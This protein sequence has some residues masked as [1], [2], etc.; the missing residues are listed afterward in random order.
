MEDL[1]LR[2]GKPGSVFW[3]HNYL[4]LLLLLSFLEGPHLLGKC[5]VTILCPSP[6]LVFQKTE[7]IRKNGKKQ[8]LK[9]LDVQMYTHLSWWLFSCGMKKGLLWVF[10]LRLP[11]NYIE[12]SYFVA[13]KNLFFYVERESVRDPLSMFG[14]Q[15]APCGSQFSLPCR[16]WEQTQ[17]ANLG[18]KCLHQRSPSLAR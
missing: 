14:G 13:E 8:T 2:P 5:S 6:W 7:Y 18:G 11:K 15:R 16:S 9:C 12:L 10:N 17:V 4:L 1:P 3:I